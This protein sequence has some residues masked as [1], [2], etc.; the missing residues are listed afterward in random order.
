[1]AG[2]AVVITL[3]AL[4]QVSLLGADLKSLDQGPTDLTV[5]LLP[6]ARSFYRFGNI[7]PYRVPSP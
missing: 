4:C 7:N 2:R 5:K 3:A 1:M 6:K